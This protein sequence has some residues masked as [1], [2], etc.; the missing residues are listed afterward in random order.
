MSF[1][2]AQLNRCSSIFNLVVQL[3]VKTSSSA[4]PAA[5]FQDVGSVTVTMIVETC[6]M[7]RTVVLL[8]VSI[9]CGPRVYPVRIRL[10]SFLAGL[11]QERL[12][13]LNSWGTKDSDGQCDPKTV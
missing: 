10:I 12:I 5:A 3:A 1:T 6:L 2:A 13:K 8:P 9:S 4:T 7:S 11:L